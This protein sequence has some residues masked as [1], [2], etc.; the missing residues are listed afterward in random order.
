MPTPRR[1]RGYIETLPSG[2]FR[3]VVPA[4]MDPLTGR[5]RALRETVGTRREAEK[6]L[7]RMQHQVDEQKHPKSG[8]TVREAI[9]QWLEVAELGVTTREQYDDL[10]RLYIGPT[11]GD[12]Q[13]EKVDAELLERF[14]S[15]LLRCKH[16]CSGRPSKGHVCRPLGPSSVRKIHYILR[17]AFARAVRWRY[18]SINPAEFVEAP[19]PAP[20]NPDPPTPQ[21]AAALLNDAWRDPEWGLL[22]WL[23]MVTG[24]R[25]GE[26]CSLR[27]QHLDLERGTLWLRRSTSQ[28]NRAAMFEKATKTEKERRIALD[29]YT[30]ELLSGHRGRIAE[31]C[32]TLGTELS[33]DAFLFSQAPDSSTPLQPRAVTQRRPDRSGA[34]TRPSARQHGVAGADGPTAAGQQQFGHGFQVDRVGLDGALAQHPPLLGDVAGV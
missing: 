26:L 30:V 5:R 27:W 23:T 1:G 4:G 11:L 3:A 14:Y 19:S 22:L 13:A 15:R 25:R 16:L 20:A 21:E 29:P 2:S 7:T 6:A 10:I 24:C 34:P 17:A 33:P 18:L 8:I 12:M 9:Q 32:A 31:R 28:P